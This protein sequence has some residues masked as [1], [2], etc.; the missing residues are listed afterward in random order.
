MSTF[1][2]P[3]SEAMRQ[4]GRWLARQLHAGDVVV[5]SG[6]LGA[7]KTT[8]ARAIGEELG[9]TS[10]VQSPTFIVARHH[11]RTQP[12]QPPLVHVDAYRLGSAAEL[13]DLDIDWPA[14][15]SVVEWGDPYVS[16]VVDTWLHIAIARP[17]AS[18]VDDL[19]WDAL[20]SPRQVSVSANASS[21]DSPTRL[22]TIAEAQ[23]DFGH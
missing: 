16:Q 15:I 20:D 22:V 23:H 3:T 17:E 12:G 9:V 6:P 18:E 14:S 21:G 2:L 7:G 1:T 10:P 11:D 19:Q 13:D 5:L 8:L 4:Y